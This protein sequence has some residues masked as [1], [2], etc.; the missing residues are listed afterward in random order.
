M[1]LQQD[2][3]GDFAFL[4]DKGA[5]ALGDLSRQRQ[6]GISVRDEDGLRAAANDFVGEQPTLREVTR[7]WRA[8]DL[9][10]GQGMAVPDE[11]HVAQGEQPRVKQ[12]LDA[13]LSAGT[14]RAQVEQRLVEFVIGERALVED[15]QRAD[16][17]ADGDLA[18]GQGREAGA[19]GFDRELLR[20]QLHRGVALA[21]DGQLTI[22]APEVVGKLEQRFDLISHGLGRLKRGGSKT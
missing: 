8:Q 9:V 22:L 14:T 16:G 13:G 19:A 5:R 11:V 3:A 17:V 6:A 21:E 4:L 10:D 20:P 7:A 18:L 12:R 15:G 1:V 2:E